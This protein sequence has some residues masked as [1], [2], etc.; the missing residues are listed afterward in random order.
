M[1]RSGFNAILFPMLM[2]LPVTFALWFFCGPLLAVLIAFV[3]DLAL[4]LLTAERIIRVESAGEIIHAVVVLE[5]GLYKGLEV[6]AGQTAELMIQSRPMIFSY[7]MPVFLA[8]AFAADARCNISRNLLALC[9]LLLLAVAAFGA[10]MDLVKSV[11]LNLPADIARTNLSSMQA[12]LIALGYQFG[13][14]IIPLVAPML[15]GCWLC[16]V[17]FRSVLLSPDELQVPK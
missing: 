14:L 13:V 6:P 8:L 12:N 10:S 4:P 7:G 2:W 16:A 1:P 11:F 3:L 9:V 15:L 17:W 5:A